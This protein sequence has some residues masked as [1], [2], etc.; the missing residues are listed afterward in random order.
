MNK[1]DVRRNYARIA[2]V[3]LDETYK[4]LFY[5]ASGIEL[6]NGRVPFDIGDISGMEM[7]SYD[8]QN[9]WR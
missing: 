7:W 1:Q 3:W 8:E 2:E 5:K 9:D 4:A 6:V